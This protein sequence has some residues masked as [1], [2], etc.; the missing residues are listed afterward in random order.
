MAFGRET[1]DQLVKPLEGAI[2]RRF[3]T[4]AAVEA[5]EVLHLE[6][7]GYV[8]PADAT[9]AAD[10]AIGIA[11]QDAASGARIDVVTYGPILCLQD[12]TPGGVIYVGTTA[13]EPSTSAGTYGTVVGMAESA[14]VL[15]V[16]PAYI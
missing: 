15:F 3:T 14:T 9:S 12:A 13:G 4:G 8:D 11:V 16:N 10:P 6:S 1:N 7:D 5:G 2:V